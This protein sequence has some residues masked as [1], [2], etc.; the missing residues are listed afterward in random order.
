MAA[1]YSASSYITGW[2][3]NS[4]TFCG[5]G[6]PGSDNWPVTW[7]DDGHQYAG[8]GD[9]S[10]IAP[11]E[12]SNYKSWGIVRFEGTNSAFTGYNRLNGYNPT[13]TQ[14]LDG[15]SYGILCMS[16]DLY[17]TYGYGS[18]VHSYLNTRLIKSTNKAQSFSFSSWDLIDDDPLLIMPTIMNKGQNY[19]DN[20]GYVYLYFIRKQGSPTQL[21]VHR[22]GLIDLARVPKAD[23][24]DKTQYKWYNGSAGGGGTVGWTTNVLSRQAVFI[25]SADGVG[26]CISVQHLA[27]ADRFLLM[28]EHSSSFRGNLQMFDAANPWGP[29]TTVHYGTN[30]MNTEAFFWNLSQKWTPTSGGEAVLFFTGINSWDAWNK[31]NVQFTLAGSTAPNSYSVSSWSTYAGSQ[32]WVKEVDGADIADATVSHLAIFDQ[33]VAGQIAA[34]A[35]GAAEIAAG[36]IVAS[37]IV[38]GGINGATIISSGTITTNQIGT[39]E[40]IAHTANIKDAIVTTLKIGLNQVTVPVMATAGNSIGL[41]VGST[42]TLLDMSVTL[43]GQPVFLNGYISMNTQA[44]PGYYWFEVWRN[45]TGTNSLVVFAGEHHSDYGGFDSMAWTYMDSFTGG[46]SAA[47][48]TYNYTLV[49]GAANVNGAAIVRTLTALEVQR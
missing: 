8:F 38:V 40:L 3:I 35:I 49:G 12:S 47:P 45:R 43:H 23:L 14:S 18:G 22:P 10:G 20:D 7:A 31:V 5:S 28:T 21:N 4:A 17:M 42:Y 11:S 41:I 6:A 37:H 24:M 29:W 13:Y 39:N 36:T 26:W 27:A 48:G 32:S 9:G 16:G 44:S 30:F 1:P 25:N 15:K 2:S 34:G 19:A 33:I 46:N